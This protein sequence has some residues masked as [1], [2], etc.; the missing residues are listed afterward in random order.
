MVQLKSAAT[1]TES[2]AGKKGTIS[3]MASAHQQSSA[4]PMGSS[5]AHRGVWLLEMD[6]RDRHALS[7]SWSIQGSLLASSCNEQFSIG[8]QNS[9]LCC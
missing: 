1:G 3:L 4:H 2:G 6:W 7:C 8:A 5:P 9:V